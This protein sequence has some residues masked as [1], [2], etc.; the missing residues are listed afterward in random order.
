MM[1]ELRTVNLDA[2]GRGDAIVWALNKSWT[3]TTQ[4]LYRF[5]THGRVISRVDNEIWRCKVPLKIRVFLW[6]MYHG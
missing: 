4:S 5:I 3:F 6:Q 2:S 1:D